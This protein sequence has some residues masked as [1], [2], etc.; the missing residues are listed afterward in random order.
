MTSV[1]SLFN[2]RVDLIAPDTPRSVLEWWHKIISITFSN[3]SL[4][5][6]F[7]RWLM[8]LPQCQ[9]LTVAS[10]AVT[11]LL[12]CVIR[13]SHKKCQNI[14]AAI[15]R[16]TRRHCR[17]SFSELFYIDFLRRSLG[18]LHLPCQRRASAI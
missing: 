18:F 11:T 8:F 5:L 4:S 1:Y 6:S 17:F 7:F 15:H 14:Q 16:Q 13:Q 10:H 2:H 9:R 12:T 3:H